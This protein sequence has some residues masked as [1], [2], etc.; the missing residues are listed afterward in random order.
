MLVIKQL[1]NTFDTMKLKGIILGAAGA[2]KRP[3]SYIEVSRVYG[4][5]PRALG[6]SLRSLVALDY[7]LCDPFTSAL[8]VNSTTQVPGDGFY[9]AI[10]DLTD[11][12]FDRRSKVD[13]VLMWQRCIQRF[14][15]LF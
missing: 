3:V 14:D 5:N 6:P 1:E 8:V 4:G 13:C 11:E 7:D 12:K 2:H 10:K 15:Y 9:D